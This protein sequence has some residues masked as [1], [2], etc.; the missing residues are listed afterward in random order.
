MARDRGGPKLVYQLLLYP[1]TDYY[2]PG[3]ASY[4]DF[5]DGYFITRNDMIWCWNHYLSSAEDSKRPYA[6][7]LRAEDLRG[8]PPA[9]VMTAECD[10]MRD[11][12]EMYAARLKAAGVAV[13]H[14][15][16]Q[17]MIHAF[18]NFA[19]MVDVAKRALADA[20]AGLRAA[21]GT[22]NA[23]KSSRS[24]FQVHRL[25]GGPRLWSPWGSRWRI[26]T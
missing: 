1:V 8:L 22:A 23:S 9:M 5:A 18:V 4:R 17:G 26:A 25:E 15:R 10:P 12:G 3:T 24:T 6:S 11:E 19:G 13:T 14:T 2:E 7:P 20:S 16:Y 21:F